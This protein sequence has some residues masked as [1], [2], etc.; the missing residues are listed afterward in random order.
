MGLSCLHRLNSRRA[1]RYSGGLAGPL[2]GNSGRHSA[3]AARNQ[4][5][6]CL[7]S[8]QL[9]RRTWVVP[10]I[11][12]ARSSM[13]SA[14]TVTAY[15]VRSSSYRQI[16]SGVSGRVRVI[17]LSKCRVVPNGTCSSVLTSMRPDSGFSPHRNA[18][19]SPRSRTSMANPDRCGL[20]SRWMC[21]CG[22]AGRLPSL[23]VVGLAA[24]PSVSVPPVG[25]VYCTPS[26]SRTVI[27]TIQ[28]PILLASAPTPTTTPSRRGTRVLLSSTILNLDPHP[29]IHP[30]RRY[31]VRSTG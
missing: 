12:S 21:S 25:T 23:R 28:L 14:S 29:G 17:S 4:S 16:R 11:R 26:A 15:T 30:R 7:M 27:L 3:T 31:G 8:F 10:T 13:L 24:R 9:R 5:G 6:A 2:C 20:V 19:R 1:T 18:Y 22:W